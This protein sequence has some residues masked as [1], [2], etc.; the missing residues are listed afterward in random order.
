MGRSLWEH[1]PFTK[2]LP[3][4]LIIGAAYIIF[5][6]VVSGYTTHTMGWWD[7]RHPSV[8]EINL[9]EACRDHH[10]TPFLGAPASSSR[11]TRRGAWGGTTSRRC[12]STW[13]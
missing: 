5:T 13:R 4:L 2:I 8:E 1:V 11:W 7:E 3:F 10:P 6:G 12:A 9:V